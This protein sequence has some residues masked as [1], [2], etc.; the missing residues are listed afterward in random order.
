[1]TGFLASVN[2]LEEARIAL[3]GGADVIDLKE[4]ASGVLGAAPLATIQEVVKFVAGRRLVSATIG[5]LPSNPAIVGPA[6]EETWACGVDIVKVGLFQ[7]GSHGSLL[8][9][10]AAQARKGIRIVMVL[11][12]D[13]E[14]DLAMLRDLADCGV[15]GVML[16]TADKQGK[17]LRRYC[18]DSQLAAFVREGRALGLMTGLAGSLR[19]EDIDPLLVLDPDYLG[20]RGALCLENS[21]QRAIDPTAVECARGRI[22][23]GVGLGMSASS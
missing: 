18:T 6:I 16:D 17:S 12:A 23:K 1:V 9:T 2:S 10:F 11:F 21:R 7:P 14:P 13:Q 3:A 22:S 8:S 4:P 19:L 5:D 15:A 20:F